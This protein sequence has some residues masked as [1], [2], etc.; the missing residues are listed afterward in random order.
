[1]EQITISPQFNP[2]NSLQLLDFPSIHQSKFPQYYCYYTDGSFT[3]SKQLTNV[4]WDLVRAGYGIWHP[5]LKINI[6]HRLIGLENIFR[7]G[8]L[9]IYH[10]L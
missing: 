6:P 8:T 7:A 10:T 2:T 9:A 5:L 4:I 3:P 1:M